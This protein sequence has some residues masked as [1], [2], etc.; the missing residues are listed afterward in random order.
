MPRRKDTARLD[1]FVDEL[2]GLLLER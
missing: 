2:L 1:R